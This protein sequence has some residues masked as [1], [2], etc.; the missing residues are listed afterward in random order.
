MNNLAKL[1]RWEEGIK[2]QGN[3]H[4]VKY[5]RYQRRIQEG[6]SVNRKSRPKKGD[7]RDE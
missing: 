5:K 2:K 3:K 6:A 7:M 1:D 4:K